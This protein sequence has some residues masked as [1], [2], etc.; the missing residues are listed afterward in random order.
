MGFK[1]LIT[2]QFPETAG[3]ITSFHVES[4]VVSLNGREPL[5]T[6]AEIGDDGKLHVVVRRSSTASS[7]SVIS[8]LRYERIL[9]AEED[10]CRYVVI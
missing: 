1:L 7:R 10:F 9:Q 5:Q 3:S 2:E 6:D 8:L 4:D